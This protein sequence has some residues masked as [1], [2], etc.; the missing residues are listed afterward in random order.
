MSSTGRPLGAAATRDEQSALASFR[1]TAR[2]SPTVI[3]TI[4]ERFAR[5]R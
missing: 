1:L 3:A 2:S 5:G 4:D